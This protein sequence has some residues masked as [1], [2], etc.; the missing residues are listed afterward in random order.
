M[1]V[2]VGGGCITHLLGV[3]AGGCVAVEGEYFGEA[4][5]GCGGVGEHA[6]GAGSA[7]GAVVVEQDGFLDSV[8]FVEEFAY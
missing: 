5:L 4:V 8:E 7:F 6:A 1:A 3:S 2:L